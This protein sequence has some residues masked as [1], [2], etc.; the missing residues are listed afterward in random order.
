MFIVYHPLI[1]IN[2][3]IYQYINMSKYIYI[4]IYIYIHIYIYTH[5]YIYI[6]VYPFVVHEK[7]GRSWRISDRHGPM[8][9][10]GAEAMR[11]SRAKR[12][13]V[14]VDSLKRDNQRMVE[15]LCV[16]RSPAVAE[17]G[18]GL[19]TSHIYVCNV[20]IYIIMYLYI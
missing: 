8:G 17:M 5:T 13:E 2:I 1:N 4:Y 9:S 11:M 12:K 14:A 19:E 6:Y 15:R 20:Y 16:V 3:S 7:N 10:S 18:V